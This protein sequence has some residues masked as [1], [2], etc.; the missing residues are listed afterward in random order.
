VTS[1]RTS[2]WK[3]I[4]KRHTEIPLFSCNMECTKT[5]YLFNS[6]IS[7]IDLNHVRTWLGQASSTNL[8]CHR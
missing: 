8:T 1:K 3:P 4:Y 6:N 2:S 5:I 7:K